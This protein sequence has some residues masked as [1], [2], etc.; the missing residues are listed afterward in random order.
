MNKNYQNHLSQIFIYFI[1]AFGILLKISLLSIEP[2]TL[3][4]IESPTLNDYGYVFSIPSPAAHDFTD[5]SNLESKRLLEIGAGFSNNAK[6]CLAKGVKSYIANDLEK[7]H[8]DILAESNPGNSRIQFFCGRCPHDFNLLGNNKFNSILADKVLHF[9]TIKEISDF[10]T[11]SYSHLDIGG[12]LFILTISSTS[13]ATKGSLNPIYLTDFEHNS[14]IF[15]GYVPINRDPLDHAVI[16]F[17]QDDLVKMVKAHGFQ[18]V[19][20]YS[21]LCPSNESPSWKDAS[22][23]QCDYVGVMAIKPAT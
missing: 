18:V 15:C 17:T 21:H 16:F 5:Q 11:W 20:T 1:C 22:K 3:N 7:K 4:D 10:L 13:S 2:T 23:D 6:T 8:L 19:K 9:L 12:S 14:E